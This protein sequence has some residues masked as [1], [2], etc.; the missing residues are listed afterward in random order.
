MI[1]ALGG[2]S[3]AN[4]NPAVTFSLLLNGTLDAGT[5]GMYVVSQILGGICAALV[6]SFTVGSAVPLA[7]GAGHNWA[8][9][10]FAEIIFTFVLC[11][12]VLNT[13]IDKTGKLS[14]F[15]G[16]AIGFVITAGGYAIGAV[17]GGSLNPAVSVALDASNMVKGGGF[18]NCAMYTLF[19]LVG[20]GAAYGAYKVC[21]PDSKGALL[22]KVEKPNYGTA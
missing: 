19:E 12:V 4:F 7:P 9:C 11:F 1:Y 5:A 2:V 16:L 22:G 13:A 6:Y 8:T 18:G 3:G 20:A 10:A 14:Q 21:R 17:S 15:F